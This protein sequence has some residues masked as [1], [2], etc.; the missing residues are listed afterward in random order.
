MR[1]SLLVCT[2]ILLGAGVCSAQSTQQ[3][4]PSGQRSY[5]FGTVARAAK[6]EHR[7]QLYNPFNS[8]MQISGVRASCGCTT[9]ILDDKV[10]PPGEIGILRARYNT[11]TFTGQRGATLTVSI[12]RPIRTELQLS[13]K[14]YIRKDVVLHPGEAAFGNI[15]QGEDN[16][17]QLTLD[18]AGRSDWQ[19]TRITTPFDFVQAEAEELSRQNGRVRYQLSISIDDEAPAG[20]I[21]NQLVLHTNDR[22][23]TSVPVPLFANVESLLEISPRQI[24]FEKPFQDQ[25][26][27]QRLVLKGKEPFRV[28]EI[29]SEQAEIDYENPADDEARR[30]HLINI[31]VSPNPQVLEQDAKGILNIKTDLLEKPVQIEMEFS[32]PAEVSRN[33]SGPESASQVAR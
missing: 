10:I 6:T 14:G 7:F 24:V 22:R 15:P 13:V 20:F 21:Q 18:Y 27:Q 8:E 29:S 11:R 25:P 12:V 23:L 3:I 32:P 2:L 30:A 5:D 31:F 17:I 4:I 16:S 28:L 26:L 33:P 9:P 1:S 19:I